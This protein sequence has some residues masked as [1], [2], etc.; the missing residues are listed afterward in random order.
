MIRGRAVRCH[1]R[2][3]RCRDRAHCGEQGQSREETAGEGS[4]GSMLHTRNLQRNC[5]GCVRGWVKRRSYPWT[6]TSTPIDPPGRLEVRVAEL[7]FRYPLAP[8]PPDSGGYAT[9]LPD[10]TAKGHKTTRRKDLAWQRLSSRDRTRTCDPLIDRQ[11]RSGAHRYLKEPADPQ[12]CRQGPESICGHGMADRKGL[13]CARARISG[14]HGRGRNSGCREAAGN[15]VAQHDSFAT[16][17]VNACAASLIPS[18][19]VR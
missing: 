2:A 6:D 14:T 11:I 17:F 4:Q 19:R 7:P 9:T 5:E 12:E 13:S 18:E 8:I 15:H 10:I 1:R 16:S 3:H